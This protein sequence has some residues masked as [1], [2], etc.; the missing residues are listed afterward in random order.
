MQK[1]NWIMINK[2]ILTLLFI[3]LI[4]SCTF[5]F[6]ESII[7][8][9]HNLSVSGPGE[10]KALKENEICIFC[11]A[12]HIQNA[13][14]PLWN[15]YSS[16][17]IYVIY[18][19][20]TT[21][22]NLRQPTGASKMCL[23]CHDGT[24]APGMIRSREEIPFT[25]G[26]PG[27]NILGINLSDDHPVS[28][29]Y[30][31]QLYIQNGQLVNPELLTGLVNLDA[32]GN[33]QCTSCHDPH[34]NRNG[35]FMV[36]DNRASALCIS[37]HNLP[38]WSEAIHRLSAATW[39]GQLPNPWPHTEYNSLYD[40]GCQNCHRSH[41]AGAPERLMTFP[42][43]EDNCLSCHNG[44]VSQK[45]IHFELNKTSKHPVTR[46]E[47]HD[48]SEN[49]LYSSRH[50][51]CVD[52]H[53]PHKS[54]E[55]ISEFPYV[56]GALAGVYGVNSGGSIISE[57]N[58][59]YELC[60]RCHGDSPG[61]GSPFLNRQFFENNTRHEFSPSNLSYHPIV[62]QGR[63]AKVPSL[64]DPYTSSSII[65]C[66]D[67]H[68]N[69]QGPNAGGAGPNGP[70][71][72]LYS[73]LLERQLVLRDGS[74]ES[75]LNYALCYKCHSR[76][77]I[78]GN[79]SFNEHSKHI[80]LQVSCMTC[81]DSHGVNNATHLINF[82]SKVVSETSGGRLKFIDTGTFQGTCYLSC[83][84]KTHDPLTYP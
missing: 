48:P 21:V 5:I 28:F 34:D 51:E 83:H 1:G 40:N 20:S 64:I 55:T 78:L 68:N 54:N 11:H 70:H 59:E 52:C 6:C 44:N 22:A 84:G 24:I 15:R 73:P 61:K 46:N 60:Y 45:D 2:V 16:G 37:C 49:I 69:D 58:F 26:P 10:V 25:L 4:F 39:N 38:G 3:Y 30:N 82:N 81:H 27:D 50:S 56:S 65:S 19:S 29:P 76:T 77:S 67:C 9:K 32:G 14:A 80:N 74:P 8:S 7:Y 12:S 31:Q 57:I 41:S 43:N 66:T 13:E 79:E 33:M 71:G 36:V 42:L 47:N 72:S 23:S 17:Q 63:N 62:S 75:Q 35:L 53:N 18:S